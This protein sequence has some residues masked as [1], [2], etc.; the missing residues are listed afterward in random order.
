MLVL[1]VR[2]GEAVDSFDDSA[3]WLTENGRETVRR[4]AGAL[5]SRVTLTHAFSSPLVRAVQSA[6]VFTYALSF[7]GPVQIHRPLA[8]G[9]TDAILAITR[10]LPENATVLLSGHEPLIREA[11]N[12]ASGTTLPGFRTGTVVGIELQNGNGVFR[13]R[14]EPATGNVLESLTSHT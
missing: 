8:E 13:F 1:F 7:S 6:E 4:V 3:R 11:A 9:N 12:L 2:H 5:E 14:V 10:T